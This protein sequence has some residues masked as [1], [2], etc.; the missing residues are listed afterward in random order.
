MRKIDRNYVND[1][2][3]VM[4]MIRMFLNIDKIRYCIVSF[5]LCGFFGMLV[6][7]DDV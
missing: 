5:F 2:F 7:W 3:S 4:F 1:Y 6:Y